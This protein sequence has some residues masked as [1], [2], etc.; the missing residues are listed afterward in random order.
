[1]LAPDTLNSNRRHLSISPIGVSTVCQRYWSQQAFTSLSVLLQPCYSF[2]ALSQNTNSCIIQM[3]ANRLL[4]KLL[5]S[6]QLRVDGLMLSIAQKLKSGDSYRRAPVVWQ[7]RS[8]YSSRSRS[9]IFFCSSSSASS[10]F[11]SLRLICLC[12]AIWYI[13]RHTANC[14]SVASIISS[15][16][17]TLSSSLAT[18]LKQYLLGATTLL[19]YD[20][21]RSAIPKY[22]IRLFGPLYGSNSLVFPIRSTYKGQKRLRTTQY[23]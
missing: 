3:M 20:I 19:K 5:G 1:M 18:I 9:F 12:Q 16:L 23:Q 14:S 22:A 4:L 17:Q 13:S 11:S 6:I 2:R 15:S 21:N 7:M 10:L 8:I